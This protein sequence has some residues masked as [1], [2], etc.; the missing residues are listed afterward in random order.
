MTP[1]GGLFFPRHT[2]HETLR[3]PRSP[4]P[5]KPRLPS[6][7]ELP[8]KSPIISPDRESK[9]TISS[10]L[11]STLIPRGIRG[12]RRTRDKPITRPSRKNK[13]EIP[14]GQKIDLENKFL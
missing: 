10:P 13:P 5:A 14:P 8:V 9:P 3:I 11:F 12:D 2:L 1:P 4:V 6:W 7:P